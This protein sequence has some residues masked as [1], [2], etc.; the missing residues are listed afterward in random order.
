MQRK[1]KKDANNRIRRRMACPSIYWWVL[2]LFGIPLLVLECVAFVWMRKL[3][4]A[5][6]SCTCAADW[7]Q[8]YIYGYLGFLIVWTV[9]YHT[10]HIYTGCKYDSATGARHLTWMVWF[11]P[12]L[13]VASVTFLVA[14]FQ[15]LHKLRKSKCSCALQG[16]G[17]DAL[18]AI[19]VIKTVAYSIPL[20]VLM[21]VATTTLTWAM[22]VTRR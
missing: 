13:F 19:T 10:F 2:A 15:Y 11:A 6:A 22:Y 20:L 21:L 3:E 17:D 1:N 18:F 12:V 4:K 8:K 9:L 14:S 5:H 7:R 16:N